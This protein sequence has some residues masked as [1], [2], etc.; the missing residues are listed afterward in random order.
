MSL[1]IDWNW[2]SQNEG[3]LPVP[4]FDKNSTNTSLSTISIGV[5]V[6]LS[7]RTASEMA[8][9]DSVDPALKLKLTPFVGVTGD[10]S[11]I[12]GMI[13]APM[14]YDYRFTSN[15]GF[16]GNIATS[17]PDWF[18]LSDTEMVTLFDFAK[19]LTEDE[20][21]PLW[22]V[23]SFLG[24]G[25]DKMHADVQTVFIDLYHQFGNF[26]P[27]GLDYDLWKQ[28]V[29]GEWVDAIAN[30]RTWTVGGVPPQFQPRNELRADKLEA[31]LDSGMGYWPCSYPVSTCDPI[32]WDKRIVSNDTPLP[33]FQD[34]LSKVETFSGT[35]YETDCCSLGKP[36][37]VPS[38]DQV[39]ELISYLW[40]LDYHMMQDL[41]GSDSTS[42]VE[43]VKL[44]PSLVSESKDG[45]IPIVYS[46]LG[47]G[48]TMF[49]TNGTLED[50][51]IEHILD[52][53]TGALVHKLDFSELLLHKEKLFY[54][55]SANVPI[56]LFSR[57]REIGYFTLELADKDLGGVL[58]SYLNQP[59]RFHITSSTPASSS[60]F[61]LWLWEP[62]TALT[63]LDGD[64]GVYL[65]SGKFMNASSN[66]NVPFSNS[67]L[68]IALHETSHWM[69]SVVATS[70]FHIR[71]LY[72]GTLGLSTREVFTTEK[73]E[74][75]Q[76]LAKAAPES[77][78]TA[79]IKPTVEYA[80][81]WNEGWTY[82]FQD[83][84]LARWS[85]EMLRGSCRTATDVADSV[86]GL[87]DILTDE[88]LTD[89]D[90]WYRY[91]WGITRTVCIDQPFSIPPPGAQPAAIRKSFDASTG[92]GCFPS[93]PP[94]QG[95]SDVFV[96]S[97]S[98]VTIGHHYPSHPDCP[99]L[100]PHDGGAS[101][102]SGTVFVNGQGIHRHGDEIS[103]GD[104][105]SNGSSNVFVG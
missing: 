105:A 3:I 31:L 48:G 24:C 8:W 7:N 20:A 36:A 43:F 29:A 26:G 96:N 37:V 58:G 62:A 4:Y 23:D 30:L 54:G 13:Y 93:R 1:N 56:F 41:V 35:S 101:G 79:W 81:Y 104:Y 46:L 55:G 53:I 15:Q 47:L 28:M 86:P 21:E 78:A 44:E 71:Q 72:D 57:S 12:G 2:I 19:Y 10:F 49:V 73:L 11:V 45:S 103:C 14:S 65:L 60:R 95:S 33:S 61:W 5:G 84:L 89:I 32:I 17:N 87:R 63:M 74:A 52:I 99:P 94:D 67:P 18:P 22:L 51:K 9:F 85:S 102:G 91:T 34:V 66:D 25:L 88:D 100:P 97:I 68:A 16:I 83:E 98:V 6:Q 64:W 92:H 76:T 38:R 50:N 77:D 80:I 90:N 42:W 69:G 75:I 39:E 82:T 40:C 59:K 27:S 70:G